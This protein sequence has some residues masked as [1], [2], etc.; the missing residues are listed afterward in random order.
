PGADIFVYAFDKTEQGWVSGLND[1]LQK[2]LI[3]SVFSISW[4][5]PEVN[6]DNVTVTQLWTES[7]IWAVEHL[8]A[9]M[10]LRHVTVV[11]SSGDMGISV[12]YPGSSA[13]VL[14][15][16]GTQIFTASPEVVWQASASASGGG[17]S[18]IIPMPAWQ[19][20]AGIQLQGAGVPTNA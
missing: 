19:S 11:V 2:N 7:A 3:P 5:W 4:G 8:L 18:S 12:C 14:S 9:E 6:A 13:L 15:C 17:I 10:V 1:I 20:A 16:G